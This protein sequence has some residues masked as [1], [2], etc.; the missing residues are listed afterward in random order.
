MC[1]ISTTERPFDVP[2]MLDLDGVKPYLRIQVWHDEEE[3]EIVTVIGHPFFDVNGNLGVRVL[4]QY[5]TTRDAMFGT[6]GIM[7]YGNGKWHSHNY[8]TIAA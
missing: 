5:G 1:E 8:S 4:E 7:P 6:L 3:L 2:G